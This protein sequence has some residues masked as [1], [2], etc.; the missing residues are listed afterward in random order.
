M[1][2]NLRQFLRISSTAPWYRTLAISL[3]DGSVFIR[4][5]G[6]TQPFIVCDCGESTVSAISFRLKSAISV[7]SHHPPATGIH[8]CHGVLHSV[9]VWL[10]QLFLR[11][12]R[13][14]RLR[15]ERT[16]NS[17][18]YLQE[19]IQKSSAALQVPRLS[20]KKNVSLVTGCVCCGKRSHQNT[21]ICSSRSPKVQLQLGKPTRAKRPAVGPEPHGHLPATNA[22][23]RSSSSHRFSCTSRNAKAR[24]GK[25]KYW[26]LS[27]RGGAS[28][29][30]LPV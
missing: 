24:S 14:H 3:S 6:T 9:P 13:R 12:A 25:G 28:S 26:R 19:L 16:L 10:S 17:Q 15:R 2:F 21:Q 30:R 27:R 23:V 4:L 22:A 29:I 5:G 8:Q 20:K 7:L 18:K 11:A 1:A